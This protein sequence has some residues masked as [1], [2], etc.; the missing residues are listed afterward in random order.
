M[1]EEA[2]ILS[3]LVYDEL[4]K[5]IQVEDVHLPEFKAICK[6]V[7]DE[8]LLGINEDFEVQTGGF[9][10]GKHVPGTAHEPYDV[11][12]RA[13]DITKRVVQEVLD[14]IDEDMD[15]QTGGVHRGVP[16]IAL[17]SSVLAK[18]ITVR[19]TKCLEDDVLSS[20]PGQQSF[21]FS[22]ADRLEAIVSDE[23]LKCV[24]AA[25][26]AQVNSRRCHVILNSTA[27]ARKTGAELRDA[28]EKLKKRRPS[29]LASER[30]VKISDSR[31]VSERVA[32]GLLDFIENHVKTSQ[33]KDYG[34]SEA[35]HIVQKASTEATKAIVG[36]IR[37]SG[38]EVKGR[39]TRIAMDVKELARIIGEEVTDAVNED[40]Q[41]QTGSGFLGP[42]ETRKPKP[43]KP[44][45]TLSES[46]AA[47]LEGIMLSPIYVPG[48][49]DLADAVATEIS[50]GLHGRGVVVPQLDQMAHAITSEVVD[51][52]NEDIEI[53]TGG[54]S[55][56]EHK[57]HAILNAKDLVKMV[58]KEVMEAIEE[59]MNIQTG[60][61]LEKKR[62]LFLDSTLLSEKIVDVLMKEVDRDMKKPD[63]K[64]LDGPFLFSLPQELGQLATKELYKNI[65]SAS[66]AIGLQIRRIHVDVKSLADSVGRQ[67]K[68]R[69]EA[70]YIRAKAMGEVSDKREI[71]IND[72][73]EIRRNVSSIVKQKLDDDSLVTPRPGNE[74]LHVVKEFSSLTQRVVE[75]MTKAIQED[76]EV[77]TG[78]ARKGRRLNIVIDAREL[79]KKVVEEIEQAI[80]ED[81]DIQT[82]RGF[83]SERNK[84]PEEKPTK[85]PEPGS[86][87]QSDPED[88]DMYSTRSS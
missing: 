60:G 6:E 63:A 18:D 39:K 81:I 65:E 88:K 19:V 22:D 24:E 84:E 37:V 36:D 46:E 48:L 17:D 42:P 13:Q 25:I 7:V 78:G 23:Y 38:G 35:G 69:I 67:L 14:S 26:S 43:R 4:R 12:L 55:S 5:Q 87:G 49:E 50:E 83:R 73:D 27:L 11:L 82:G 3:Q 44:S 1:L 52:I 68:D 74:P 20:S 54:W 31:A 61:S 85:S 62:D 58:A 47:A 80:A 29:Y 77:Q 45:P 56:S 66:T 30:P 64:E 34:F 75:S 76:I 16:T 32:S 86:P 40:I 51:A 10:A 70:S 33:G 9:V 28:I 72:M 53:Q 15:I 8:I 41:I 57:P 59:D 79:T 21:L 71:L 2:I